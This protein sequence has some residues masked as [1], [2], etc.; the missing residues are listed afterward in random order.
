LEIVLN[1]PLI[2]SQ[3]PQLETLGEMLEEHLGSDAV[4]GTVL[5]WLFTHA[6]GKLEDPTAYADV[7]RSWQDEWLLGRVITRALQDLGVDESSAWH[8]VGT[9]KLLTA[10]QRWFETQA[11]KGR[12]AFVILRDLLRD[13]DAQ[14]FLQVNRY[15]GVLWFNEEAYEQLMSWLLL[16]VIVD[17]GVTLSAPEAAEVI[18]ARA[19]IVDQLMAAGDESGYR[20]DRLLEAAGEI[21]FEA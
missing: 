6:L 2:R 10:H 16:P 5:G 1:L 7:S 20:V 21:K 12:E 3:H 4:W 19:Q 8:A 9:I 11:P 14:E 17:A 15:Q 18:D 13:R